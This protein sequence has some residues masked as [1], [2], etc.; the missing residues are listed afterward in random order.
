MSTITLLSNEQIIATGH[1][2]KA[3]FL[4][5]ALLLVV[6]IVSLFFGETLAFISIFSLLL[7]IW[8]SI[9]ALTVILTSKF[10]LTNTRLILSTGAL[11]KT[12]TEIF[13]AKYEGVQIR[14]G[15]IGRVFN[16]GTIE[17]TSGGVTSAYP[18]VSDPRA[19]VNKIHE[20]ANRPN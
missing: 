16:Y 11:S 7:L 3:V 6:F 4:W 2:S 5:P 1:V 8:L 10:I 9:R 15:I 19:F 20:V 14:Q 17:A 18:F 12:T 13:L